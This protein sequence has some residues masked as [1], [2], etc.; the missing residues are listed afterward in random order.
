MRENVFFSIIMPAFNAEDSIESAIKSLQ[1]QT[2]KNFELI[3]VNDFSTDKTLQKC[4]GLAMDD[5][6]IKVYSNEINK[7]VSISRNVALSKA[8]GIYI[9]FL[10]ADDY[11]D[12]DL[13]DTVY[14]NL[15][16]ENIDC[17]KFGYKEE[18]YNDNK[19]I[20]HKVTKTH[21]EIICCNESEISNVIFEL[22]NTVGFGYVWNSFYRREVIYNNNVIFNRELSANED[23][24]FNYKIFKYIHS[25]KYLNFSPYHYVKMPSGSITTSFQKNYY[26][27]SILKI[28]L[29]LSLYNNSKSRSVQKEQA[30][31]WGYTRIVYSTLMRN[32]KSFK[33]TYKYIV[34]DS[35][36]KNIMMY[37]VCGRN[38]KE[39]IMIYFL[40]EQRYMMLYFSILGIACTKKYLTYFFDKIK[41]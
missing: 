16:E 11:V 35:L 1:S 6:R 19:K 20:T 12:E 41:E 39:K 7:G 15:K 13:L 5:N 33:T 3:I 4:I 17:I 23:F 18:Y 38:M 40:R 31:I 25:F 24:E 22:Y 34:G 30:L 8:K 28:F 9:G 2:F 29:L 14:Q 10:D 36:Y 27:D 37:N 32:F 26:K 21:D